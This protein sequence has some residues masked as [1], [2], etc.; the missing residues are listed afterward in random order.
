M[1]VNELLVEEAKTLSDEEI[2]KHIGKEMGRSRLKMKDWP[3]VEYIVWPKSVELQDGDRI[4]PYNQWKPGTG[5]YD[6]NY[7]LGPL[8]MNRNEFVAWLEKV[9]AK[10]KAKPKAKRVSFSPYD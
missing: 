2:T 6:D 9:G 1:K 8:N 3:A 4:F 10:K 5:H 7:D